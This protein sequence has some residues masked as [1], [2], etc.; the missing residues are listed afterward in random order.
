MEDVQIGYMCQGKAGEKDFCAVSAVSATCG[1]N[2][3]TFAMC[4]ASNV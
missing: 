2:W 4:H 1:N 3:Q